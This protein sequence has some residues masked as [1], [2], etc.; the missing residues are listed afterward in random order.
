MGDFSMARGSERSAEEGERQGRAAGGMPRGVRESDFCSRAL[1]A[2]E[3]SL[4]K[5]ELCRKVKFR[6]N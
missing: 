1:S 3:G 6:R 2:V 4:Q 5:A